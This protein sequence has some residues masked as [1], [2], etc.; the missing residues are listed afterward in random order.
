MKTVTLILMVAVITAF[1]AVQDK[2]T[3]LVDI[4]IKIN[5]TLAYDSINEVK[6]NLKEMKKIID[7]NLAKDEKFHDS[8]VEIGK[9]LEITS[10][11]SKI[12]DLRKGMLDVS[13][14]MIDI[15]KEIKPKG[16]YEIHC[17]MHPGSWLNNSKKVLNP[18][19]GSRMRTCGYVKE[20]Y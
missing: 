6:A 11:K 4:S 18:Y 7:E 5:D 2:F 12:S 1:S 15:A 13:T 8:F 10:N 3:D 16:Y 14:A 17:P 20:T 9:T 19:E